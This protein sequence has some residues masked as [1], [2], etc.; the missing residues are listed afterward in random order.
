M[1]TRR[2]F[3]QIG[4][5][6]VGSLALRS[7][8]LLPALA[9]S[10]PDYR[11]LVCVFLLGGN[12]SNNMII[13]M[14][15][16]NYQAYRALRGDIALTGSALAPTVQSIDGKPYA[17]HAKLA[18]LSN[19]FSSGK[20]AVAA[21]V[22]PL[23]QPLSRVQFQQG[24][25]PVPSNLFSHED[26][27]IRWQTSMAQDTIVISTETGWAGRAA[28]YISAQKANSSQFPPFL[29]VA[30]NTLLGTGAIT[31]PL[32]I[33]P[34]QSLGLIGFNKTP[35]SQRRWSALNSLLSLESGVSLVQASN[36]MLAH[37]I[38][39]ATGLNNALSKATQLKTQF[40]NTPL[41]MQLRQVAQIIQVHTD[42]GMR[43]QIFFCCMGG[44]DTH[45]SELSSLNYIYS[46]LSP[47]L[48]AFF[49]ATEEL[50]MAQSVTTFTESEFNRTFQLTSGGGTD[51]GWG[52]HQLILG[53][54]V[55]GGQVFGRFPKFQFGGPDDTDTRGR[56]IPTTSID[57]YGATLCSWFGIPDA[58]LPSVFP[59]LKNFGS[60]KLGF[61]G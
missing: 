32:V 24:L 21:N 52:G 19:L 29:S 61:M 22:G 43:R 37:S 54:A 38:A 11:A 15:D 30:G 60:S 28:D 4:A 31:Q 14:D 10:S 2:T 41:G 1:F 40:P 55:Q 25:A 51:H 58:I 36:D 26:Q 17:F 56:W 42:L 46:L 39:D 12:D 44:F 20:L 33:A 6:S 48:A 5:A 13:P 18:E 50:G 59:N 47:A 23:V 53:G 27:T 3:C 9:Q 49:D 57:Q 35:A 34:G 16:A 45:T 7:F 8:G